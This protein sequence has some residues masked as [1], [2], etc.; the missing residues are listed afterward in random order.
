[1]AG[2]LA[3]GETYK[4]WRTALWR[5]KALRILAAQ[6]D[7]SMDATLNDVVDAALTTA[8]IPLGDNGQ[9]RDSE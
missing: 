7:R 4:Q 9:G 2:E 3:P 6:T 8:G 5:R 1:M